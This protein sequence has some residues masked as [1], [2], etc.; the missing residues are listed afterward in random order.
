[1]VIINVCDQSAASIK[2]AICT[3]LI[4]MIKAV[5]PLC[6]VGEGTCVLG[7]LSGAPRGIVKRGLLFLLTTESC[8]KST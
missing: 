1:M 7:D 4:R 2:T 6:G 3:R 5:S 8:T